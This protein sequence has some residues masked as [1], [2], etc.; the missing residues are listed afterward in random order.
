[1]IVVSYLNHDIFAIIDLWVVRSLMPKDFYANQKFP[2]DSLLIGKN[3][4]KSQFELYMFIV[5][6][7]FLPL[8]S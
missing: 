4:K 5:S 1:M 3:T 8:C 2:Q 7:N 6:K